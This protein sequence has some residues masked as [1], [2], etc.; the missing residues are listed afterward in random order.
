MKLLVVASE[1]MEFPGLLAHAEEKRRAD[2]GADWA[3]LGRIG[4]NEFLMVAN[5][6]GVARA[7]AALDA[8]LPS[9][10]PDALVSIGF[11]GALDPALGIGD[12]VVATEVQ[13]ANGRYRATPVF[14]A[15]PYGRGVVWTH[16]R[17]AETVDERRGLRASGASVV[18]MEAAAVAERAQALGLPFYCVKSVTDLAGESLANPFN[19]ALREDGHFD[20]IILLRGALRHPFARIP[21]LIRLRGRC[22]RAARSL[23]DFIADCRF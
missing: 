13:G 19:Q 22:V 15:K 23:G 7:G 3:R 21:E 11:C 1:S 10:R 5:G 17:V 8:A 16:S 9:F 18:E 6:A 20:T 14:T 4:G 12:I 2:A